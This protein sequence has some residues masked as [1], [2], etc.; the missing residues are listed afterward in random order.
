MYKLRE[1]MGKGA[2]IVARKP[3]TLP[4]PNNC[5]IVIRRHT[6]HCNTKAGL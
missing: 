1:N 6:Q 3:A 2:N 4:A 5:S